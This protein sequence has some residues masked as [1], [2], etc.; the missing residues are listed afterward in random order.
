MNRIL[1]KN[2]DVF[3]QKNSAFLFLFP[4]TTLKQTIILNNQCPSFRKC[5][6]FYRFH[7][8]NR[9]HSL[10]RYGVCISTFSIFGQKPNYYEIL[11]L[12]TDCS[13][14]EIRLA[15][16]DLCKKYHPDKISSNQSVDKD[17][18]WKEHFQKINEA[19]NCLCKED[20]RH[21]YDLS[22]AN[23]GYD[24]HRAM[25]KE[26][27]NRKTSNT[28]YDDHYNFYRRRSEW[29]PNF[30]EYLR[31]ENFY[32]RYYDRND[33]HS[34]G[35]YYQ[36]QYDSERYYEEIRK[37]WW[38]NYREQQ[39]QFERKNVKSMADSKFERKSLI[40]IM[41]TFITVF[42]M[43]IY[44]DV[45]LSLNKINNQQRFVDIANNYNQQYRSHRFILKPSITAETDSFRYYNCDD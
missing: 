14:K 2:Y 18:R 21:R 10:H 30:D 29:P 40:V 35:S 17:H 39:E 6:H 37:R 19:Y 28:N 13:S 25:S 22:L 44:F 31:R 16:L 5:S 3:H 45:L 34:Y 42:L 24:R 20:S 27:F 11:G 41:M 12:K 43:Q 15:Y 1:Q 23:I 38:Q 7:F 33:S 36:D 4:L 26:D 32:H 8:R 9:W